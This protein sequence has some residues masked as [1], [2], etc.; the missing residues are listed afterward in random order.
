MSTVHASTV[1]KPERV[2]L[3]LNQ[4]DQLPTLPAIATRVLHVT[5]RED[6]SARDVVELIESD[7]S[8]SANIPNLDMPA[9][10]MA[11]PLP[12]FLRFFTVTSN[13]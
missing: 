1:P 10:A 12:S 7:Q 13:L 9:P 8:L 2:D 4:L 5:T 6:S 11:T 3:I